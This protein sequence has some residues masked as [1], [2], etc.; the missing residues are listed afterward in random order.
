MTVVRVVT[1]IAKMIVN[2]IVVARRVVKGTKTAVKR[3]RETGIE[4]QDVGV[5]DALCPELQIPPVQRLHQPVHPNCTPAM[6]ALG[7]DDTETTRNQTI[8]YVT[9]NRTI[10]TGNARDATITPIQNTTH[11]AAK[12][13]SP[14]LR[15]LQASH[16]PAANQ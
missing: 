16:L 10:T 4:D 11:P 1:T 3:K 12:H 9:M 13:P 6:R 5:I 14:P 15:S 8:A 7:K 2:E